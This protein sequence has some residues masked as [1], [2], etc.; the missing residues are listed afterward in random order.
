MSHERMIRVTGIG[1]VSLKP[2]QTTVWME[3]TD[4]DQ[5]YAKVVEASTKHTG[6]VKDALAAIGFER[7]RI[8]TTSFRVDV[9]TESYQDENHCWRER[10]V[11]YRAVHS[12]KVEF[13]VDNE[14]LGGVMTVLAQMAFKPTFRV[15]YGVK[16]V[17]KA[18]KT[19]LTGAMKD[20][21]EKAH[22]LAKAAGMKLGTV[23][24]ILY[25]EATHDFTAEAMPRMMLADNAVMAKGASMKVDIDPENITEQDTVHVFY[26]LVEG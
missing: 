10:F 20:A 22:V 5:D 15:S 1:R 2:D 6:E 12:A 11:G 21:K 9:E 7:D 13:D 16:D 18:R 3:L 24:R 23:I 25:G 8:K 19:L 14:K 17:E 4:R 26:E